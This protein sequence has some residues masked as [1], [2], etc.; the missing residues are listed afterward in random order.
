METPVPKLNDKEQKK[1]DDTNFF[2]K[3]LAKT[4]V[5]DVSDSDKQKLPIMQTQ[6]E[7]KHDTKSAIQKEVTIPEDLP[8]KNI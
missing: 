1:S 5:Q 8:V 2:E 4:V 7:I 6:Q 3:K